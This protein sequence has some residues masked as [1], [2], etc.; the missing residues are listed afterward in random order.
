MLVY[1]GI[2]IAKL[3]GVWNG[4]VSSNIKTVVSIIENVGSD[5]PN[6]TI[7]K[8]IIVWDSGSFEYIGLRYDSM[9]RNIMMDD[10]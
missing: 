2:N 9:V 10:L 3:N 4:I 7:K 5:K 6:S 8:D 1:N